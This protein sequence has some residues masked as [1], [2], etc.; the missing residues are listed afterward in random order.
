M[1]CTIDLE[2][3]PPQNIYSELNLLDES[4]TPG[5][6]GVHPIVLKKCS[7]SIAKILK[8]IF[9]ASFVSA[10]RWAD[11]WKMKFNNGKCKVMHIGKANPIYQ[12]KMLSNSTE[13]T[14]LETTSA[15]RDLGV[16]IS[17]DLKW[18][19]QVQKAVNKANLVLGILK[20]TFSYWTPETVKILYTCF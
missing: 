13:C 6:D 2:N 17:K 3:F 12:Y 10:T 9:T 18:I 7:S 14:T 11:T 4:K 19:I 16:V 20:R 5:A 15:E 1:N 8:I